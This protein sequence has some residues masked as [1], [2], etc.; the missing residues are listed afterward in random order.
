MNS[1]SVAALRTRQNPG[2]TSSTA[3]TTVKMQLWTVTYRESGQMV[4]GTSYT[5]ARLAAPPLT[6]VAESA[7]QRGCARGEVAGLAFQFFSRAFQFFDLRFSF[8]RFRGVEL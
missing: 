1:S 4:M 8:L 3:V 7:R 2:M 6:R 5:Q